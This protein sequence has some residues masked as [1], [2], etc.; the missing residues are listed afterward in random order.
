MP[1]NLLLHI[2]FVGLGTALLLG[3]FT[4]LLL[5]KTGFLTIIQ[6]DWLRFNI[7]VFL[8]AVFAISCCA[9]MLP[10]GTLFNGT[11]KQWKRAIQEIVLVAGMVI[12]AFNLIW[13]L[14]K[15]WTRTSLAFNR[16]T[17]AIVF[18]IITIAVILFLVAKRNPWIAH[19][20]L[21]FLCTTVFLAL[22]IWLLSIYKRL[23]TGIDNIWL[24]RNITVLILAVTGMSALLLVAA[25][26]SMQPKG[27][28]PQP[29]MVIN[30]LKELGR[31]AIIV[32]FVFNVVWFVSRQRKIKS[33]SFGWH[34]AVIVPTIV[35]S[36]VT[37]WIAVVIVANDIKIPADDDLHRVLIFTYFN[38]LVAAF[39]YT[40]INYVEMQRARKL[41]EKE[42]EVTRLMALKTKAELDA[43]HSKVNPHFLYNAL[44]SIADLSIT[45][46]R[47][48]RRMTIALADLFR[49]S[50]NYSQNNYS[51][52]NDE[53]A[54]T[55]VYL[56]IEKIRFEDQLN[57]SVDVQPEAGH[58]LVPRFILQPLVENAV[59]HGLKITG[60]MTEIQLSVHQKENGL[61]IT[62]ADN[63]PAFPAEM[64]PGYGVKSVF[65]KLDLLFPGQYE[66]HFSNEP[67]KQVAIHIYK[68][69]KNEPAI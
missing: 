54:M 24:R 19:S 49:Y 7:I 43:L 30:L 23:F 25:Q 51:T 52:V 60:K 38:G 42:L 10:Q 35:F 53:V 31:I 65:D 41:T 37:I 8:L 20:I 63:G 12:I 9:I 64:M 15:T 6:N 2:I 57:Y 29:H 39:I 17:P 56:Q 32:L 3:F 21:I 50:I 62:I 66:I 36:T 18:V 69:M 33:L 55:E 44:N 59:K 11:S 27:E 16:Y 46:G 34:H 58:Y 22:F 13:V 5:K 45:D 1:V 40:A 47:K 4:W 26:V 67:R 48:A 61:L 28:P 14:F 68:L